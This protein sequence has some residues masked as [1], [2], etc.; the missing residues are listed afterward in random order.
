[1]EAALEKLTGD[2]IKQVRLRRGESQAEFSR[3]F[4]VHQT[5]V[6]Y[7]EVDGPPQG[8]PVRALIDRVLAELSAPE[9]P[10]T[11]AAAGQGGPPG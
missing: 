4:R 9:A 8:G 1:M 7:W 5:T 11:A 10:P 3:W 2:T 6:H